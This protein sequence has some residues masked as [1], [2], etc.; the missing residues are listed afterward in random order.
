MKSCPDER[1]PA[2]I[3]HEFS[4]GSEQPGLLLR[5]R[6]WDGDHLVGLP[7]PLPGISVAKAGDLGSFSLSLPWYH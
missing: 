7:S 6:W 2:A 5:G 4:R 3:M 1:G